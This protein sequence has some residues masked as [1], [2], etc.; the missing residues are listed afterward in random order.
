M[1]TEIDVNSG[2]FTPESLRLRRRLA[3]RMMQ[4]GLDS[5]PIQHWTQGAARMVNALMGG[6]QMRQL[7]D[8][9]EQLRR[10]GGEALG[11]FYASSLGLPPPAGGPPTTRQPTPGSPPA[12]ETHPGAPAVTGA[13]TAT[14][15]PGTDDMSLPRSVRLNNPGAIEDGEF[16]RSLPGYMGSDG[17]Y[18][19][20][21]DRESGYGAME[22][23]LRIY[24]GRGQNSVSTI[25]GGTPDNP[26]RSWAPRSVD[27][28]STDQYIASVARALGV[29]PNAPLTPEMIPRLAEAMAAYEAG[30]PV[31]RLA[32]APAAVAGQPA[33]AAEARPMLPGTMPQGFGAAMPEVVGGIGALAAPE[34]PPAAVTPQTGTPAPVTPAA[35]VA[36]VAP[37]VAPQ[38]APVAGASATTAP[39]LT[40]VSASLVQSLSPADRA[41]AEAAIRELASPHPQVRAAAMATLQTLMQRSGP[42]TPVQ[43][44]QLANIQ[45]E[46]THRGLQDEE[47][48][49]K[50][51]KLRNEM[52]PSPAENVASLETLIADGRRLASVPGFE[53]ALMLGRMNLNVGFNA[54]QYGNV[55]GNILAP[56]ISGARMAD[57]NNPSFSAYDAI[58]E[59][60]NRLNLSAGRAFLRGSGSVSNFERQMVTDAIGALGQASSPADFQ[61]RL[62]SVTRMIQT[63]NSGGRL[64]DSASFNLRPTEAEIA[65]VINTRTNTF[66][67][68]ALE[69]LAQQYNVNPADLQRYIVEL[70]RRRRHPDGGSGIMDRI[71]SWLGM[72]GAETPV[73]SPPTTTRRPLAEVMAGSPGQGASPPGVTTRSVPTIPVGQAPE[74]PAAVPPG[75]LWSPSRRQWRDSQGRLYDENGQRVGAQ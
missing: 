60:Q 69:R 27:N 72:A 52:P 51:Q 23:L 31:P 35:P 1:T 75:S 58:G 63:L 50:T 8:R 74:R 21:R 42:L 39:P 37:S 28:N 46:I 43:Q 7:E 24:M 73:V 29:N 17:R 2:Q 9:E 67:T 33:P 64:S 40:G 41:R 45:S 13:P 15:T 18:A 16:A 22:R 55:G 59:L 71:G 62:N 54:G 14:V 34:T 68:E 12:A 20:F 56:V 66:N 5:S 26:S 49:L 47:T 61:F 4:A 38:A 65:T 32:G 3:E 6:M 44:A 53:N 30:V 10:E 48:R 25:I 19:R 70:D 36:P 11:R 57:P